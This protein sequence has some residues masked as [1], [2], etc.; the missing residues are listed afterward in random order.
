M[1]QTC[2]R[3]WC[4]FCETTCSCE[5]NAPPP[6][7]TRRKVEGIDFRKALYQLKGDRDSALLIAEAVIWSR[8]WGKPTDDA[9]YA[10]SQIHDLIRRCYSVPSGVEYEEVHYNGIE[11]ADLSR[12]EG[13]PAA[14][15]ENLV[16]PQ[17]VIYCSMIGGHFPGGWQKDWIALWPYVVEMLSKQKQAIAGAKAKHQASEKQ[18]SLAKEEARRIR[19]EEIRRKTE[20]DRRAAEEI[21]RAQEAELERRQ[22]QARADKVRDNSKDACLNLIRLA[23][24]DLSKIESEIEELR[25]SNFDPSLIEENLV[26]LNRRKQE[27]CDT[28]IDLRQTLA[29]IG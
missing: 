12:L 28:L 13:D 3:C 8:E 23:E 29:E 2:S 15:W 22:R 20:A 26:Q 18:K 17:T 10:Q 4:A 27:L 9:L 19:E 21:R 16:A 25:Y 1:V 7:L 11:S 5:F 14:K 24:T 6:T